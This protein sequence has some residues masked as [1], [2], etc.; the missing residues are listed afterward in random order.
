MTQLYKLSDN[1]QKAVFELSAMLE[2]GDIDS[3]TMTDTLEGVQGELLD[4]CI[5]TG[6]HIKNLRSDLTQLESVKK[7]FE[8]RIKS[9]KSSLEFFERYLDTNMQASKIPTVS[10][11]YV[12]IKY[13][14]LPDIVECLEAPAEFS[15][16]VPETSKPD[17]KK[18]K[19]ALVS[20]LELSFAKMIINRTKLD[21]K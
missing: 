13:K 3:D 9:V 19:D 12:Q 21:I 7:E 10:N 17:K 6:L 11:D 2:S 8:A 20:G 18:I 1:Y 4:K 16:V 15:I 14:K 5:N